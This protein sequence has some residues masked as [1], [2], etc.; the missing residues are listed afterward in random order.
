M[1]SPEEAGGDLRQAR[2]EGTPSCTS[3]AQQTSRHHTVVVLEAQ[4]AEEADLP[5][6]KIG[7]SQGAH[8]CLY[9]TEAVALRTVLSDVPRLG[10]CRRRGRLG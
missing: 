1:A 10:Q 4:R 6:A 8:V 7:P 9:S 2:R 3:T 5:S